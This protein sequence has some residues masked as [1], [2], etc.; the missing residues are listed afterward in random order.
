MNAVHRLL[1]PSDA[2]LWAMERDPLL[3]S[4]VTAVGLLDRAPDRTELWSRFELAVRQEPRL[5]QR[6]R[7]QL[8][9]LGPPRWVNDRAFDLT[10][11]VR[12]LGAVDDPSW[13]W[14]FAALTA[15]EGFDRSQALWEVTVVEDLP[16]GGAAFVAKLHHVLADGLGAVDLLRHLVTLSPGVVG[17]GVPRPAPDGAGP[18]GIAGQL[19]GAVAGMALHP[20]RTVRGAASLAGS[21]TRLV[22][23][24]PNRLSPLWDRRSTR[25]HFETLEFPLEALRAA[26][27]PAG[28]T[29]NDVFVAAVAGG[30][31][32]YLAKHDRHVESLRMNL[33]VSRR[34]RDDDPAGNR[35]T[36]VRVVLDISEHDAFRRVRAV[37]T[38]CRAARH[39][40]ALPLTDAVAGTLARLPAPVTAAVMGS[41]LKGVDFVATN[42]PGVPVP[43]SL[44]GAG[45][46]RL[47]AFA[48]LSGAAL[49]VALLSHVGL[50]CIGLNCDRAVIDDPDVLVACVQDAFDEVL[51]LGHHRGATAQRRGA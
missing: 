2:V 23:P 20:G 34:R 9:G 38:Q 1:G 3:C 8:F 25:W 46:T 29:V 37:S 4:T 36:P 43:C 48:P 24:S 13:L 47:Y 17:G 51:A 7:G 41:M 15:E 32:R 49:N 26:G 16:G 22:A 12:W 39:E 28:A 33:P 35:F 50:A 40:P 10:A 14:H 31:H 11:H 6:V 21:L 18:G 27:R 5:R 44:A 19:A 42:V 30:L 45:L